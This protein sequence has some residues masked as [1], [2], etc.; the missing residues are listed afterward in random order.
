MSQQGSSHDLSS[1]VAPSTPTVSAGDSSWSV[2]I[3]PD[4]GSVYFHNADNNEDLWTNPFCDSNEYNI[5]DALEENREN[6]QNENE[7][8]KLAGFHLAPSHNFLKAKV[9][10]CCDTYTLFFSLPHSPPPT[11]PHPPVPTYRK[12][13]QPQTT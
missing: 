12:L 2:Q 7:H 13:H 11:P 3:H 8:E 1:L 9:R 5:N 6:E 4:S 10:K